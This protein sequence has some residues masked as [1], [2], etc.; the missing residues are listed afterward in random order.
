VKL[1]PNSGS[2]DNNTNNRKNG[3]DDAHPNLGDMMTK[4]SSRSKEKDT[5]IRAKNPRMASTGNQPTK[6]TKQSTEASSSSCDKRRTTTT[7]R[8]TQQI[9]GIMTELPKLVGGFF[10]RGVRRL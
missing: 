1:R 5:I 4:V 6:K 7:E 10:N 3:G 2:D 9:S 8:P